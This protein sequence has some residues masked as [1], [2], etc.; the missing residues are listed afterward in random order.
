MPGAGHGTERTVLEGMRQRL[1]AEGEFSP[2]S[3]TK[4]T[5]F[6]SYVVQKPGEPPAYCHK[7]TAGS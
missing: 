2:D 4:I 5:D 7:E 6:P 1:P 3:K